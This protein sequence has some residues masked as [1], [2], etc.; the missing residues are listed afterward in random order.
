VLSGSLPPGAV[1]R[2]AIKAPARHKAENPEA[3]DRQVREACLWQRTG[4]VVDHQMVD[5][6]VSDAGLDKGLGAGN[7]DR[8][9]GGVASVTPAKAGVQDNRRA[10]GLQIPA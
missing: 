2:S 5:I 8:A 9:G 4:G 1:L 6:V 3:V 10:A 7:T